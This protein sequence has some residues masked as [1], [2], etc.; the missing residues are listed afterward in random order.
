MGLVRLLRGEHVRP[1]R[2]RGPLRVAG[3]DYVIRAAIERLAVRLVYGI[4]MPNT[5]S[6][7]R[8]EWER[9]GSVAEAPNTG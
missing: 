1:V 5:A 8:S 7:T 9:C 4:W 3:L 6:D 2:G